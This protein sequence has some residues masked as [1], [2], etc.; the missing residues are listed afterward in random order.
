LERL[1]FPVRHA[2]TETVRPI[3]FQKDQIAQGLTA[4]A[5]IRVKGAE[6]RDRHAGSHDHFALEK[7][8][9][10]GRLDLSLPVPGQVHTMITENRPSDFSA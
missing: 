10:Q 9:A 2:A 5:N 4:E 1:S 6:T 8:S 3:F 7:I